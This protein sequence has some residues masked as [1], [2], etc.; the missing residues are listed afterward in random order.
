MT[1]VAAQVRFL[2]YPRNL[3]LCLS[4]TQCVYVC[5]KTVSLAKRL[6]MHVLEKV[7]MLFYTTLLMHDAGNILTF[8]CKPYSIFI[9]SNATM[10]GLAAIAELDVHKRLREL[11]HQAGDARGKHEN[12]LMGIFPIAIF[13]YLHWYFDAWSSDSL[14]STGGTCFRLNLCSDSIWATCPVGFVCGRQSAYYY[15]WAPCLTCLIHDHS[16]SAL[17]VRHRNSSQARSFHGCC[18]QTLLTVIC[19]NA[20]FGY[21]TRFDWQKRPLFLL[22]AT[23]KYLQS[24]GKFY[25]CKCMMMMVPISISSQWRSDWQLLPNCW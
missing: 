9:H 3:S 16:M 23:Q 18:F 14:F 10:L 7:T 11:Q 2:H 8:F 1:S 13:D 4:H 21:A 24:T 12:S 15:Q 22:H 20:K 6:K 25:L 5:G 17:H 19:L